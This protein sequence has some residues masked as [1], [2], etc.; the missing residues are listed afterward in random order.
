[1]V[2]IFK[3]KKLNY[4]VV[5]FVVSL[6]KV[7]KTKFGGLTILIFLTVSA[8]YFSSAVNCNFKQNST[9]SS[10]IC[11]VSYVIRVHLLHTAFHADSVAWT[12]KYFSINGWS[13]VKMRTEDRELG[14][15]NLH[16]FLIKQYELVFWSALPTSLTF[17]L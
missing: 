6:R 3:K 13:K 14:I 17:E 4:L 16:D 5:C 15:L 8:Y 9:Y 7:Y 2:C 10:C 12:I 11:I 1:M